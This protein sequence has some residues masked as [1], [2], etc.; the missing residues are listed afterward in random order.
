MANIFPFFYAQRQ[1]SKRLALSD[2]SDGS[3]WL[4]VGPQTHAMF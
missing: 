2:M 4:F 3:G 1:V